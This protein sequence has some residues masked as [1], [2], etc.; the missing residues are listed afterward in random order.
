MLRPEV[1]DVN[2]L[3]GDTAEMLGRLLGESILLEVEAGAQTAAVELDPGDLEQILLNLVVNARD[4]MP[5]GGALAIAT[6]ERTFVEPVPV[7]GLD[8]G[9]YVALM[10][11]DTGIGMD[12]ATAGQAFEPFFTTKDA[13]KGTGLG[14]STVYGIATRSGGAIEL[15]TSPGRGTTVTVYLPRADAAPKPAPAASRDRT[16][17]AGTILLVEDATGVRTVVAELL[18]SAGYRVLEASS[19]DAALERARSYEGAIDLVLTD[20]V[21]PGMRGPALVAELHAVRPELKPL[22]MSGYADDVLSE[23]DLE[24][25]FLLHKPF[26]KAQ[27][28]ARVGAAIESAASDHPNVVELRPRRAER[29]LRV[30]V[31]DDHPAVLAAVRNT[32]AS[33]GI[34]IVAE[35]ADGASCVELVEAL[36]PD[37]AIFDARMPELDGIAAARRTAAG[38]PGTAVILYSGFADRGLLVQATEA[39]ARGFVLKDAPLADLVRAVRLVSEGQTYTDPRL[40]GLGTAGNADEGAPRLTAR[41]RDVLRLAADGMTNNAIADRLAISPETVQT[42]VRK[43]MGKLE[44]ESRTQA[45]AKALRSSLIA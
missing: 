43:A 27:L 14:L 9:D 45:V 12:T 31:A 22:Y 40:A 15:E 33:N 18:R 32:F 21:M 5:D 4:A 24:H 28:L 1:I 26:S 23:R 42:H 25:A 7:D 10:V 6:A 19:G 41:E 17:A 20:V 30:V 3:I 16:E 13:G 8:P 39:G 44:A 37:V 2:A 38:A 34:E 35:A 11:A 29:T 36:R